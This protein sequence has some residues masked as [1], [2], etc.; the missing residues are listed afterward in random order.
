MR[1][2][3]IST[4]KVQNLGSN[5]NETIE[6]STMREQIVVAAE[7]TKKQKVIKALTQIAK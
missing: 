1:K 7:T 6:M 4:R 3:K 2:V 5:E